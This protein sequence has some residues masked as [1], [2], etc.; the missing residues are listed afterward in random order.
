MYFL[1]HLVSML[2]VQFN[3]LDSW[4]LYSYL[5]KTLSR[6]V[7]RHGK[8]V[9]LYGSFV[10]LFVYLYSLRFCYVVMTRNKADLK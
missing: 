8:S 2:D 10:Q 9:L 1:S 6:K 7:S 3:C 5:N 4:S